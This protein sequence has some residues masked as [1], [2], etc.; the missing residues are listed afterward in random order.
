VIAA[1]TTRPKGEVSEPVRH[2][3][4]SEYL[5]TN[6]ERE[7]KRGEEGR[8]EGEQK[9]YES[10]MIF[11]NTAENAQA[12]SAA[13]REKKIPC[14]EYHKL[15]HH[16]DRLIGFQKFAEGKSSILVCTDAAA[17]GLDLPGVKH[18][19]QAEF[20]LNVVHHLHRIGRASRAGALGH[21][22]NF[23]DA[24]SR[25]LI[26]SILSEGDDESIDQ[27]FSRRRGFRRNLKR[28]ILLESEEAMGEGDR[29]EGDVEGGE[30][31]EVKTDREGQ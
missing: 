12:L 15:V 21:A 30:R 22:T 2:L 1:L 16:E 23:S 4:F 10:T 3:S 6:T 14:E 28:K 26:N 20:A 25:D 31:E 17:R 29:G 13:L 19:I 24:R 11:T 5:A 7:K 18:V 9:K 27:S 8:Q